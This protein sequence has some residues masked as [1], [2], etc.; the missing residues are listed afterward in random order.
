MIQIPGNLKEAKYK[1]LVK[2][3]FPFSE[4]FFLNIPVLA[5]VD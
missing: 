1:T 2:G 3:V 4:V 5:T